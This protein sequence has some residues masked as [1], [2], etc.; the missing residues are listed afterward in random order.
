I[1]PEHC[2][3]GTWGAGFH[4]DLKVRGEIVQKGTGG[5]DGYSGF[6]VRDPRSGEERRTPLE[7]LL[8]ERDVRRVVVAGLATDYCVKETALDAT[9][10]GF[11]TTILGDAI[12]AVDLEAGDGERA[13]EEMR[14]AGAVVQ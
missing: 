6:T 13:V 4:P 14:R 9:R 11:D 5:E 8:R 1:W 2:V 12:R 7:D 10:K 3:Q